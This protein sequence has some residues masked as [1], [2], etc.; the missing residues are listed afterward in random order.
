VVKTVVAG[1]DVNKAT[2]HQGNDLQ[3]QGQ[4]HNPQSQGENQDYVKNATAVI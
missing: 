3:V 4:G 2:T 1:S